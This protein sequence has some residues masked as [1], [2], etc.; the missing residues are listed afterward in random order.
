MWLYDYED[1]LENALLKI[2][3]EETDVNNNILEKELKIL[4]AI[5]DSKTYD[6]QYATLSIINPSIEAL[7][8]KFANEDVSTDEFERVINNDKPNI[9]RNKISSDD[10]AS[11]IEESPDNLNVY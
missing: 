11:D 9:D 7:K 10:E 2:E 4:Y 8:F 3:I 6:I 5:E 1:S